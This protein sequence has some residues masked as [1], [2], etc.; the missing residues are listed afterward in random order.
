MPD[1]RIIAIIGELEARGEDPAEMEYWRSL[2]PDL[3]EAAKV[4]LAAS[5]EKELIALQ[6]A[7]GQPASVDDQARM[8]QAEAVL[9]EARKKDVEEQVRR[10]K[11][12]LK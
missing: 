3:P 8:A 11:E 9:E 12:S 2:L 10:I 1:D 6:Q 7:A 5:L 4:E